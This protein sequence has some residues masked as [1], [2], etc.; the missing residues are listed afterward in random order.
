MSD[1]PLRIRAHRF[2]N[3]AFAL[4]TELVEGGDAEELQAKAAELKEQL[5]GLAEEMKSAPESDRG[6]VNRA[7]ADARLD[8][9]YVAAGGNV[10]SSIRLHHVIEGR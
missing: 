4:A 9:D 1:E 10:P 8:L 7:L 3:D 6:E 2:S 5:S